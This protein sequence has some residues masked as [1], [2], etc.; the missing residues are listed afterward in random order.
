MD[1]ISWVVLEE[2]MYTQAQAIYRLRDRLLGR[3]DKGAEQ[4]WPLAKYQKSC[5]PSVKLLTFAEIDGSIKVPPLAI[6][7]KCCTTHSVKLLRE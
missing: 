5:S 7:T 3:S 1:S 4:G 6:G 2:K